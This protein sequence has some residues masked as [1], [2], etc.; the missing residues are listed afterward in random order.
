MLLLREI[1][2]SS[3][4]EYLNPPKIVI[5]RSSS[6]V[7]SNHPLCFKHVEHIGALLFMTSELRWVLTTVVLGDPC[8]AGREPVDVEVPPVEAS[9]LL[10]AEGHLG[11]HALL[12][13]TRLVLHPPPNAV[14][15]SIGRPGNHTESRSF[16]TILVFIRTSHLRN[17]I[18]KCHWQLGSFPSLGTQ[19]KAY[20]DWNT[21]MGS[22]MQPKRHI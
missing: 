11:R 8:D 20:N 22:C 7:T 4:F 18:L 9:A 17:L 21:F 15:P 1:C 19:N 12:G 6:S 10:L 2:L 14:L 5:H 16:K 13:V 3:R